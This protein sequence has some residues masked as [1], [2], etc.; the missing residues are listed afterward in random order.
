MRMTKKR[1]FV[2]FASVIVIL[3][4]TLI[5][6]FSKLGQNENKSIN[7]N[8]YYFNE[9][10]TTIAEKPSEIVYEEDD[11]LTRV[12]IEKLMQ[13]PGDGKLKPIFEKDIKLLSVIMNEKELTVNFSGEYLTQDTSKN[14]LTTYAVVK[15]LCQ[16]DRV[17]KV[18]V[19]V[20]G[21]EISDME[22][23]KIGFLSDKDIDLVSDEITQD[24]KN[25]VLYFPDKSS[26]KLLSEQRKIKINDTVPIEQYVVNE[27]IKGTQS[28]KARNVISGDTV[29]ISAQTTDNTC[30]VNFKSS[31]IEKNSGN[32]ANEKLVIYS[33]VN[34]LCELRDVNFVQ[35]LI[36][37]KKTDKFGSIDISNF[38]FKEKNVNAG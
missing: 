27:L 28:T 20:S 18:L 38:F 5:I 19:T 2:G 23:N 34:S 10:G 4:V 25:I 29:L 26:D 31:F 37:G 32:P 16:L 11:D 36:D 14:F 33:I 35:F 24:S 22:G 17:D 1:L 9:T 6:M 12:V 8:L 15:S 7:I 21:E 13:G 30:F 3:I